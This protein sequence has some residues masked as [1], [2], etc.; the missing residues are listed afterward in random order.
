MTSLHLT[1]MGLY[2][3]LSLFTSI[4]CLTSKRNEDFMLQCMQS[5]ARSLVLENSDKRCRKKA[6]FR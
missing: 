1:Y 6:V 5:L 3:N 2:F 4:Y